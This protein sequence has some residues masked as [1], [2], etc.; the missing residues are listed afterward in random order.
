LGAKPN[1]LPAQLHEAG[2]EQGRAGEQSDRERDLCAD[3]NFTKALLMRAAARSATAF[4][5]SINQIGSR[6]LQRWVNAHG[7]AR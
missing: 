7:R 2:N 4:F 3:Q 5:Q 6:T 1:V